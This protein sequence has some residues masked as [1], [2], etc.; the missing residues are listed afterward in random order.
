MRD[1]ITLTVHYGTPLD[2]SG[3]TVIGLSQSGRTPDVVEYVR[4]ARA[5]GAFTIARDERP[6]SE[7]AD[8]RRRDDPPGDRAR[9]RG[10][11]D[12]DLRQ[13]ARRARAP[14]RPRRRPRRGARRRHPRRSSEL[15]ERRASRA[16]AGDVGA[17]AAVRLHGP[18]VRDRARGRVRDRARDRP[19]AARD[20]PDRRRA[21]DRDRP[22]PRARRRA[23]PAL[24]RLGDRIGRRDARARAGGGRTRARR[25]AR[26]SSRAGPQPTGSRA[27]PTGCPC[28]RRTPALLSPLLSVVPGQLF[29]WALARARGL[30]PDAPHG[31]AKVTLAR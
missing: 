30:D 26:R 21:A 1:S 23:R 14:R 16:R 3:S 29:A 31:L 10:R 4:G 8:G 13:H 20:L 12:E 28:R 18:D 15:L 6:G 11:G 9:A 7:L 27:R 25:W 22:R 19:Q 24:P 5:A 2:M 17:R